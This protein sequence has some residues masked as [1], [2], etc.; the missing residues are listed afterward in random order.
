MF[1]HLLQLYMKCFAGILQLPMRVFTMVIDVLAQSYRFLL[2]S[3]IKNIGFRDLLE[4]RLICCLVHFR[5]IGNHINRLLLEI[6]IE[7]ANLGAKHRSMEIC[8]NH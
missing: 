5:T 6:M 7:I 2:N 1:Q 8:P 4:I 3:V